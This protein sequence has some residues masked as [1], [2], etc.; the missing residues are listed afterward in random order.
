MPRVTLNKKKYKA[1]DLTKYIRNEMTD[2]DIEQS[3]MAEKLG[4]SQPGF[5]KKLK[6]NQYTYKDL[7]IIFHELRTPDEQIARLMKL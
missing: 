5:S 2:M 1:S 4:I 6:N 3:Y 7:L